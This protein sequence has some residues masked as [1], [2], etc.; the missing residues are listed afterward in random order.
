MFT[1]ALL[2]LSNVFMT[3]AWYWYTKSGFEHIPVWKII[4]ISWGIALFEYCLMVPANRFGS[5]KF[6]PYELKTIQEAVSL[7][8]FIIF[9]SLYLGHGLKWNYLVG[10]MMIAA[11]VY[12]IFK[13]W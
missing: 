7:F 9:A 2:C 13:K 10:F 3:F 8:V 6:N 5:L 11:A 1:I 12:I 4:I